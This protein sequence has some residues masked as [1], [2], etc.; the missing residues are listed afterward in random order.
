MKLR[1]DVRTI[2]KQNHY[3][4]DHVYNE[5]EKLSVNLIISVGLFAVKLQ[6]FHLISICVIEIKLAFF[7]VYCLGLPREKSSRS[8]FWSMLSL[9]KKKELL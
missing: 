1:A 2:W 6:I 7:V 5:G 4:H 8:T 9:R 3:K